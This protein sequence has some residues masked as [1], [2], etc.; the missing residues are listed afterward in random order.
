MVEE[1]EEI[2]ESQYPSE[3]VEYL[4]EDYDYPPGYVPPEDKAAKNLLGSA[5][6]AILN[7][8][9]NIAANVL[10][11]KAELGEGAAVEANFSTDGE[12]MTDLSAEA[13]PSQSS[14][15]DLS[16]TPTPSLEE[17]GPELDVPMEEEEP[18]TAPTEASTP[19]PPEENL[20]VTLVEDEDE[21]PSQSTVTLLEGD[22]EEEEDEPAAQQKAEERQQESQTYCGELSSLSCAA[23]LQEHLLHWCSATLA[24]Q[25][26]H[27][28][29]QRQREA[30]DCDHV[31]PQPL[32]L[33]PTPTPEPTRDTEGPP[34]AEKPAPQEEKIVLTEAAQAAAISRHT[35]FAEERTAEPLQLEPSQT[36][37]LPPH[38][39][40]MVSP[41]EEI[42]E[43]SVWDLLVQ[44]LSHPDGVP[45]TQAET[46]RKPPAS[47][48]TSTSDISLSLSTSSISSALEPPT[49]KT[50]APKQDLPVLT[51][52]EPP[53]QTLPTVTRPAEI[54]PPTELPAPAEP[55]GDQV[56][57]VEE[58]NKAA[59]ALEHSESSAPPSES[60]LEDTVED[61]LLSVPSAHSQLPR[62]ATDFYA[63]L[64]NS[65]DLN[66][67]N[68][69][70]NQVHGSNQKES[71]FMRLNNRI[72]ALEMN[73]SLSSRYLE[74]LSQ[75]Y[76]K[77][78]EE[79]QRAFNKTIIKLQNT[80]RIA[81]E[82]DQK[83]TEAIQVLQSQLENVTQLVFNLSTTVSQLQ[84]EVSDR[85]SLLVVSL[86]LC[87]CLG[88]LLCIQC[89]RSSSQSPPDSS[90]SIPKSNHYPSPK[91]CFS[92]YDDMSLR[93]RV[94]CP[95][96][97]SKSFQF[98]TT[99]VGPDDLY[100][101]E[102]LRFSPEKKKK[103]CKM[104]GE[105][106]ETLKP[107]VPAPAVANGGPKCNGVTPHTLFLSSG[108][109]AMSSSK[110]PTSE[111]SSEGS[112][113][114][115]EPYFCGIATCSRLCNGQPPPKTKTEKKAF[116]R[117]RSKLL[118]PGRYMGE[119]LQAQTCTVPSL[120][121][122]MKG[123]K[124]MSVGNFG[125]AAV[126]GH[127]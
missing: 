93:R 123:N 1:Y 15:I 58:P 88:L 117:R 16:P 91:R 11:G 72:K 68:G 116:K 89:C 102:P 92:S 53:I 23:S 54:P 79:M 77:Q 114:S 127:V 98:P 63:E 3:R 50:E 101:V 49:P 18:E 119:V 87:L 33:A 34:E 74:E 30:R 36:A 31:P 120:G 124:D 78:M 121:N 126:S 28:D 6:N 99:E 95:L 83:Q 60:K 110:D 94:S 97:R 43:L 45:E 113:H 57:P 69:N 25:R 20:I 27:S 7:M 125:V 81:E 62:T 26:Q 107:S 122:I 42:P 76:R 82:Q 35:E 29:R 8:V 38:S 48:S 47:S 10:G 14:A 22:E 108:E 41:T 70:G 80:S 105:K 64:Q 61:L 84:R 59:P 115:D 44:E 32:P 111:G 67:G 55:E 24:L 71:V 9:N 21:E 19:A 86:L 17:E 96:V 118:E 12:N 73:M 106:V 5:T 4:D 66:Y 100:I 46:R 51:V 65:T 56:A 103:R 104:K 52:K 85:Q 40:S 90:S 39:F 13:P 75:R 2:A 109:T 112:S 37:S